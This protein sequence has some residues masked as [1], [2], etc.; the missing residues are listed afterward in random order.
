MA[1][2]RSEF[3]WESQFALA[4]DK[5]KPRQYRNKCKLEDEEMCSMCGEYCAVKIAKNEF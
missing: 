2:S 1:K 4:F 5:Y 3:D